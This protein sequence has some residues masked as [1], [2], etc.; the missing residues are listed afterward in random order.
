MSFLLNDLPNPQ[1]NERIVLA[2]NFQCWSINTLR[3]I[4]RKLRYKLWTSYVLSLMREVESCKANC[5]KDITR[6][7]ALGNNRRVTGKLSQLT[8][9]SACC[10]GNVAKKF[11]EKI[12][13]KYFSNWQK[14]NDRC[15]NCCC[16]FWGPK[17]YRLPSKNILHWYRNLKHAQS[18]KQM[19]WWCGGFY[20]IAKIVSNHLLL[21]L[22]IAWSINGHREL[23][24]GQLM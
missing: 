12:Q 19:C 9:H 24:D 10:N 15:P 4:S 20:K 7:F 16:C 22:I 14:T 2:G 11:L 13:L 21:E 23:K 17:H 18:Q 6:A 3:N 1:T 8:F 5:S